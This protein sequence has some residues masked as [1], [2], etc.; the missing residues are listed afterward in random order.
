M[1]DRTD[2]QSTRPTAGDDPAPAAL[3]QLVS[4]RRVLFHRAGLAALAGGG[5][6][7]LAA[8]TD[9]SPGATPS[10]AAPSSSATSAAPSSAASSSAAPSSAAP[11]SSATSPSAAAS[12]SASSKPEGTEVAKS[13][14]PVGGGAVGSDY[15]VTQPAAGQ[16]K[17]FTN[18]C[19]HQGCLV[20]LV[21]DGEIVC[22]CHNSHFSITDGSP[23][24]GPAQR[25]LA[26]KTV[27]ASGSNLFV[28]G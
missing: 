1:T 15:V 22:K 11:S 21:T 9:D 2:P 23:V 10:A 3:R 20:S 5:V 26:A 17:A 7:A 13:T 24:S 27:V 16:Y 14:V 6:V 25:A 19:T 8:C 28:S 12:T 18:V 4:T